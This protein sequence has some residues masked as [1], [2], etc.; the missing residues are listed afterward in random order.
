[1]CIEE[2]LWQSLQLVRSCLYIPFV[3]ANR[4]L[5]AASQPGYFGY[6]CTHFVASRLVP[7]DT[8]PAKKRQLSVHH[9]TFWFTGVAQVYR[10]DPLEECRG[11]ARGYNKICVLRKAFLGS[12]LNAGIGVD[13]FHILDVLDGLQ[14]YQH[15]VVGAKDTLQRGWLGVVFNVCERRSRFG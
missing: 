15:R 12:C 1:V 10:S 7:V 4:F 13:G 8:C 9:E 3:E 5:K 2:I 14:V 11:E 6:Q